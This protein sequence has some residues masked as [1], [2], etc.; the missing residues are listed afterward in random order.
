MRE[1]IAEVRRGRVLEDVWDS[2]KA[3]HALRDWGGVLKWEGGGGGVDVL[4]EHQTE[5]ADRMLVL[6]AFIDAL[7]VACGSAFN[8]KPALSQIRLRKLRVELLGKMERFRDQ[9]EEMCLCGNCLVSIMGMTHERLKLAGI[10][11]WSN[12]VHMRTRG[13]LRAWDDDDGPVPPG[14]GTGRDFP[15]DGLWMGSAFELGPTGGQR[16]EGA[17]YFQKARDV[18]A[19]HGFILVESK[20][21]IGLGEVAVSEGRYEEGL[22]LLRN[23]V[24]A[25]KLGEGEVDTNELVALSPLIIALFKTRAIGEVEPLVL[26]FRELSNA[27]S[28]SRSIGFFLM[29]FESLLFNARL[30]EVLCIHPPVLGTPSSCSALAFR[31]RR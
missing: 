18:G 28:D 16:Q 15:R 6:D 23:G 13:W 20:A 21:C 8:S 11:L 14:D 2:V 7:V 12:Y 31:Q 22:E 9:G 26:R 1:R 19:A 17:R 27:L 25:A 3:A 24:V 29:K 4:L 10:G 5:D 30:H